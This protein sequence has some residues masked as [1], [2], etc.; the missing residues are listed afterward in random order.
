MAAPTTSDPGRPGYHCSGKRWLHLFGKLT[1]TAPAVTVD[2]YVWDSASVD[3]YKS[4]F[5]ATLTPA[6]P[7]ADFEIRGK[8]RVAFVA[9]ARNDPDNGLE[10]WASVNDVPA[11]Q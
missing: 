8:E 2:V 9:S 5:S 6:D 1:G 7:T 4:P 11:D 10:L 3:W